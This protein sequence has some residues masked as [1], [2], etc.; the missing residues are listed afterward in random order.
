MGTLHYIDCSRT[1]YAFKFTLDGLSSFN[2]RIGTEAFNGE[3]SLIDRRTD[4]GADIAQA[5]SCLIEA[6]ILNR[7]ITGRTERCFIADTV[8]VKRYTK[9]RRHT[10]DRALYTTDSIYSTEFLLYLILDIV[11]QNEPPVTSLGAV[12]NW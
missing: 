1:Y 2:R 7:M 8:I 3:W 5:I 10:V 11:Q 4:S 12:L 6:A 9:E